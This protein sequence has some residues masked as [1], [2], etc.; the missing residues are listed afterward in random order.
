MSSTVDPGGW[1]P[2]W[3][4]LKSDG[5][6][7]AALAVFAATL[8]LY[9][10]PVLSAAAKARLSWVYVPLVFL[11]LVIA[12]LRK[13][14]GQIHP[15]GER[16]FWD[17]LTLAFGSWT[18]VCAIRLWRPDGEPSFH[19]AL[20][21]DC[22]RILC[23][24]ALVHA[25]ERRVHR[26]S[27]WRPVGLERTLTLPGV[28]V[29]ALGLLAYFVLIPALG[30]RREYESG[31]PS[32]YLFLC[33]DLYLTF[34]LVYLSRVA[35]TERWRAIYSL[36]ALTTGM[37]LIADVL[38]GLRKSALWDWGVAWDPLWNLPF[39]TVVLAA[40]LRH[41][42]F[43]ERSLSG[44]SLGPVEGAL[45]GPGPRTVTAALAF[46]LFHF[47]GY[48][49]DLLDEVS[50]PDR[51]TLL[52]WWLV[53]LG[54]IA[55]VQHRLL[56]RKVRAIWRQRQR[57][58][59]SLQD[60]QED[61]RVMVERRHAE[62]KLRLSGRRFSS[63]FRSSPDPMA[64]SAL[65]DGRLIAVN[66]LFVELFGHRRDE[67]LGRTST[68][69]G[70]WRRP[71]DRERMIRLLDDEGSVRDLEVSFRKRSGGTVAA[72]LAAE[73]LHLAGGP[74]L[75]S[76]I[77]DLTGG[78]RAALLDRAADAVA[79]L[80]RE[81]RV[82]RWNRSAERLYGWTAEEVLGRPFDRLSPAGRRGEIRRARRRTRQRGD[83]V[84]E[85]RGLTRDGRE[86]VVGSWWTRIDG[87]PGDGAAAAVL[88]LSFELTAGR[89]RVE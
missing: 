57:F 40:R 34:H 7:R 2:A 51:E 50:R 37:I 33:L 84:G 28:A 17:D 80:D 10:L 82:R 35:R 60:Q 55:L 39:L 88:V 68:E 54:S 19:Q 4:T 11:L 44:S 69:V 9:L 53:L 83:W 76:S 65:A 41:H 27:D 81:G 15:S 5:L 21:E 14:L 42:R 25:V 1:R 62:E 72:L 3:S 24:L 16:R 87:E 26:R 38:E 48:R 12:A 29:F 43:R 78:G 32:I 22:L 70:L 63:A 52:L 79:V 67:L 49:F 73:P 61:L 56:D 30:N 77:R 6:V 66:D 31:L 75:V 58:E 64:I 59:A 86:V 85:L 45:S 89:H 71:R 36:L 46:P 47:A 23:Y 13:D 20:A 8:P 18:A 74:C